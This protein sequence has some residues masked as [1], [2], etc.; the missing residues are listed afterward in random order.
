MSRIL[1]TLFCFTS[2]LYSY[3][4]GIYPPDEGK[5]MVYFERLAFT[6]SALLYEVFDKNE[7]TTE[8]IGILTTPQYIQY[9][10]EP[11]EHLFWVN[12][13]DI[14]VSRYFADITLE[15]NRIY[16]FKLKGSGGF[17]VITPKSE[18]IKQEIN[19]I[20]NQ[21]PQEYR[22]FRRKNDNWYTKAM[23]Q[24]EHY[25]SKK[26]HPAYQVIKADQYYQ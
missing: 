17:E 15:K 10:C 3:S 22:F 23:K 21:K 2:I 11:G 6:G 25:K 12:I 8:S 5:V 13:E 18:R 24:Y 7:D 9:E 19:L 16:I 26:K 1:L 20:K 14:F 4:Q